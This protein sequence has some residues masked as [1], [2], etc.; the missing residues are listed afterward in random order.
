MPLLGSS[1]ELSFVCAQ[2][3][4]LGPSCLRGAAVRSGAGDGDGP[5]KRNCLGRAKAWGLG[6]RGALTVGWGEAADRGMRESMPWLKVVPL[7]LCAGVRS[8]EELLCP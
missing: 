2:T 6:R 4:L 3:L 1:L 7:N 8:E 5:V